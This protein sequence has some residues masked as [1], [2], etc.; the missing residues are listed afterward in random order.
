MKGDSSL[1]KLSK[2][3][4]NGWRG[5]ITEFYSKIS[6]NNIDPGGNMGDQR[7]RDQTEMNGINLSLSL[8]NTYKH[9]IL[10]KSP[11][12]HFFSLTNTLSDDGNDEEQRGG[13]E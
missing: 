11:S 3:N 5:K 12:H 6:S 1:S 7:I 2:S 4:N 10:R 13:E 9:R 8:T